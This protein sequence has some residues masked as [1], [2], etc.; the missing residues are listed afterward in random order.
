MEA[1]Q[2]RMIKVFDLLYTIASY[3]M[4]THVSISARNAVDAKMKSSND[5]QQ[6]SLH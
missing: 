3:N 1:L 5:F 6:I 4:S 2:R